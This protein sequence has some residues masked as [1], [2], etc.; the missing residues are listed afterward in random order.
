MEIQVLGSVVVRTEN[1]SVWPGSEKVRC[2]L[3]ALAWCPNEFVSDDVVIERIWGD[4]LP[5]HPRDALYTCANRLRRVL[6]QAEPSETRERLVRCRNGYLLETDRR[7]VDLHEFRRL[8]RAAN[9][10]AREADE[11]RAAE[12]LDRGLALWRS[13]P[14]SDLRSAWACRARVALERERLAARVGRASVGLRLGRYAEEIPGLYRLVEDNPLDEAIAGLLMLALHLGGRQRDALACYATLRGR[15]IEQLG[16]EPG[17]RL[18]DLHA[19][20]LRRDPTLTARETLPCA[21]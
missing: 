8:T 19:R 11:V 9:E 6:R 7:V 1:G 10:A 21:V 3:A 12:L 4:D 18:R 13:A 20:I 16:D 2:L 14:M 17:E 5:Q 15:L